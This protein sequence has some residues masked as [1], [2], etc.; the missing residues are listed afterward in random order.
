MSFTET[1][2][3]AKT[4]SNDG[5]LRLSEAGYLEEIWK[6]TLTSGATAPCFI[7]DVFNMVPEP[8]RGM[9]L[10]SYWCV[11]DSNNFV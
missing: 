11:D 4:P 5:S 8:G 6:W 1:T 2:K 3:A 10:A 7:R 9:C